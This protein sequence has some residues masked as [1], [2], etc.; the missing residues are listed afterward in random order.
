MTTIIIL[1][2]LTLALRQGF[3]GEIAGAVGGLLGAES[4]KH[5]AGR[6]RRQFEAD[7]NEAKKHW[8]AGHLFARDKDLEALEQMRLADQAF[9]SIGDYGA[10]SIKQQGHQGAMNVAAALQNRGLGGTTAALAG[11]RSANAATAGALSNFLSQ[12]GMARSQHHSG[13]ASQLAAMGERNYN[14]RLDLAQVYLGQQAAPEGGAA[15]AYGRMG[16]QLGGVLGDIGG[17]IGPLFGSR[18]GTSQ[19]SNWAK[20]GASMVGKTLNA[21]F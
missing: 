18:F 7:R 20:K 17:S 10:R 13:M 5:Q 4:D 19:L 21:I 14:R 2:A 15:E 16:S 1:I 11:A 9:R 8:Y 12:M 6:A 3:L